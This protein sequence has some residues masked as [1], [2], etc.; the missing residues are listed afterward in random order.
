M[1][2]ADVEAVRAVYV[3]LAAGDPGPLSDLMDP[4]IEWAEPEGAPV[5]A[6]VVRGRA[7]VFTE[8]FARIPEVWQEFACEP[9]EFLDAGD[10]VVV[11]GVLRVQ[12]VGTGGR[13]EAAFV[14]VW[15]L[16]DGR[17][18]AWRCHTDTALLQAARSSR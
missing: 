12:G 18:V 13:A 6:G 3:A 1:S 2:A 9:Q 14:H 8:V 16:R 10:R 4:E 7:A 15:R 11:T 5:I 17:A